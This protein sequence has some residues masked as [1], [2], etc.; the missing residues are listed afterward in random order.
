MWEQQKNKNELQYLKLLND[1]LIFGEINREQRAK[2]A[3]GTK[4]TTISKFGTHSRYDLRNGFTLVTTKKVPFKLIVAEL[5][6]FLSG[7]TNVK[8]L[9]AHGCHIWDEWASVTGDLGPIYGAQWRK[10][11][12]NYFYYDQIKDLER[13]LK[14]DPYSRRH[15]LSAWNVDQI[16]SMALPPC[17]CLAQFYVSKG[18]LSCQL[19]Q[20][21]GDLFLG[22]PFNIASYAL[23]THLL[24]NAVGLNVG[25]FIHV[26]GDAHIYSNHIDQVSEQLIRKPFDPPQIKIHAPPGTPSYEVKHDQIELIGYKSHPA[27]KGEV[28]I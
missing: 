27:L 18:E 25:E 26:I 20:R 15:I 7:S 3:D 2:L 11:E 22:V 10:W 28:A 12:G 9:Q 24:A 16:D 13:N 21:S 5:L 23:L 4:P 1:V 17:H 14:K 8:D 6:W 19:Y